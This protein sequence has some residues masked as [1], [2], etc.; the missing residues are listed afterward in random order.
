MEYLFSWFRVWE[1][2]HQFVEIKKG[3]RNSGE[4]LCIIEPISSVVLK[5]FCG[6]AVLAW[7][8]LTIAFCS[9]LRSS[10]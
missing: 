10:G 8:R 4:S 3:N 1:R 5:L 6:V 2:S 9:L 7:I